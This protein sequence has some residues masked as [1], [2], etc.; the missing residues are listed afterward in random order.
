MDSRFA[1]ELP[2]SGIFFNLREHWQPEP[3]DVVRHGSGVD[4][5]SKSLPEPAEFRVA[6]TLVSKGNDRRYLPL[7]D[8]SLDVNVIATI[9]R[10]SLKQTFSNLSNIA[11]KEA[12]YC[13]PLYDGST[14]VSFR[15][16]IG[17]GKLLEGKVKPK[18]V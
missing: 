4:E 18:G 1:T 7:L 13:F 6:N 17:N 9:S 11:I 5:E 3:S 10:T 12:I 8:V 14:V 15:C 2:P 16:W